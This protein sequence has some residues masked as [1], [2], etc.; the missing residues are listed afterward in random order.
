MRPDRIVLY[1]PLLQDDSRLLK[2]VEDFTI[3]QLIPQLTFETL[4]VTVFPGATRFD[5]QRLNTQFR[6]PGSDDAIGK[7]AVVVR[8]YMDWH[9]TRT[10]QPGQTRLHVLCFQAAANMDGKAFTGV[11]VDDVQGAVSPSVMR[12]IGNK[13]I[14]PHMA[15]I[16]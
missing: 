5:E 11:F 9:P 16:F 15:R 1:A 13:V 14:A 8:T 12:P 2:R 10:E 3:Q 6:Q 7:F 4:D